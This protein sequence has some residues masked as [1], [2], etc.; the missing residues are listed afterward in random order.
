MDR[1]CLF[2]EQLVHSIQKEPRRFLADAR[3]DCAGVE[4]TDDLGSDAGATLCS[5]AAGPAAARRWR[6]R[7]GRG[8]A[9]AGRGGGVASAG[10]WRRRDDFISATSLGGGRRHRTWRSADAG[11]FISSEGGLPS[12]RRWPV[13]RHISIISPPLASL[14]SREFI[15]TGSP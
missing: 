10:W 1:I 7:R 9:R 8:D 12:F 15:L 4:A 13:F 14:A 6:R 5:E 11:N 2:A 3:G